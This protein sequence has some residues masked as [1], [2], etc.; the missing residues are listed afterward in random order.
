MATPIG[1]TEIETELVNLLKQ[2]PGLS[3][4]RVEPLPD[5]P[6]TRGKPAS[7]SHCFIRINSLK[8]TTGAAGG[9]GGMRTVAVG[10]HVVNFTVITH[11]SKLRTHTG[12]Y[13]L[14]DQI[15][16]VLD[17]Y[18]SGDNSIINFNQI[19]SIQH[20]EGVW[21]AE[22]EFTQTRKV[23]INRGCGYDA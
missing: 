14:C 12:V 4:V 23:V 11:S 10:E 9:G 8:Q 15:V 2:H 7:S 18:R 22:V 5:S 21:Q 6:Q 19:G 3:M 20:T 13:E 16:G 17:G 1:L